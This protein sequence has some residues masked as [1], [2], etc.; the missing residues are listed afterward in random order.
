MNYVHLITT[1]FYLSKASTVEIFDDPD[2]IKY[3]NSFYYGKL[4][5]K[6]CLELT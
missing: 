5:D 6:N 4:T 3:Y 2:E 1:D